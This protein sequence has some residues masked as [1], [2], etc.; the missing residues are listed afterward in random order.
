MRAPSLYAFALLF[1]LAGCAGPDLGQFEG[2]TDVGVVRHAGSVDYDA[3]TGAY[4]VVGGGDNMW[5]DKDDFH[6][7]W[8]RVPT[9]DLALSADIEL[10]G[11]TG[12]PHRKAILMIR[13][14]LDRDAAY[15]SAAVHGNGISALQHREIKGG[16]TYEIISNVR[17]ARR[18]ALT[19]E[20]DVAYMSVAAGADPLQPSGGSYKVAFGDSVYVGIG[21]SAHDN[22]TTQTAVFT[23]VRLDTNLPAAS[24]EPVV[25]S[26][27]EIIPVAA[28]TDRRVVWRAMERFEAPNWSP[29]GSYLLF[30][31][32]GGLYTIPPAGG[33]PKM[34][35]TDPVI[36]A[37]NDH[38]ITFDG[39]TLIISGVGPGHTASRVYTAPI[40][41]GK[42]RQ[43]TPL[44]PSYWHGVSPDGK[45]LVYVGQRNGDYDIYAMPIGGGRER[46]LTTAVGLDDGPE[47][48]PDGQWIYFNSVRTGTMQIYRMRPDGSGQEQLT[49][50]EYN[51][52]FPHIS[53]DGQHMVFVSFEP[54]VEGHPPYHDVMLRMMPAEGGAVRTVAKL[55]GGQGTINVN[56]WSPDSKEFAFVSHRLARP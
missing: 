28:Y 46:R 49:F 39:K 44:E 4:T 6:Y 9:R 32:N 50:D 37:N 35:E 3:A 48:S 8:K 31:M 14:D 34:I 1:L 16:I 45:T 41:G 51:D 15:V 38:G 27:L 42:A 26:T 23:D 12:N 56:S 10:L 5:E 30:N 40:A 11:A 13:Q 18:L 7:I 19:R 52:W 17:Q 54:G 25:E 33:E 53:P 22:D 36:R 24:G 47:Y 55:F 21:V 29:D 2:Q 20:G 43:I